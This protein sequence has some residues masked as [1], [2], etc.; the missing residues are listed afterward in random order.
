MPT[1]NYKTQQPTKL[2]TEFLLNGFQLPQDKNNRRIYDALRVLTDQ[3]KD[4]NLLVQAIIT[5]ASISPTTNP[6]LLPGQN[7]FLDNQLEQQNTKRT[8]LFD[9]M[10]RVSCRL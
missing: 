5:Q 2:G 9:I 7:Q 10:K 1:P 3:I 4:L 6:N 8:Q